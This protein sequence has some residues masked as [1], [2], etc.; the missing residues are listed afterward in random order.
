M[1]VL[2]AKETNEGCDVNLQRRKHRGILEGQING[3]KTHGSFKKVSAKPKGTPETRVNCHRGKEVS[4]RYM[5]Y[6]IQNKYVST[7]GKKYNRF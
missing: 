7:N 1:R 6:Y 2:K 5:N 3:L 4:R